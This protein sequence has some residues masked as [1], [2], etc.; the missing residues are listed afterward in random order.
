MTNY[1]IKWVSS[2]NYRKH[3]TQINDKVNE[4]LLLNTKCVMFLL[5]HDEN[6]YDA[7]MMVSLDD[8][9]PLT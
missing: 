1:D 6:K 3:P 7:L 4:L 9:I 2:T 5:H 8:G